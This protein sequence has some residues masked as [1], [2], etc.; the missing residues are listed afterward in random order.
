MVLDNISPS[1]QH[2]VLQKAL[3]G[4]LGISLKSADILLLEADIA[5]LKHKVNLQRKDYDC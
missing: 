1:A 4:Q 5:I 2:R 3:K